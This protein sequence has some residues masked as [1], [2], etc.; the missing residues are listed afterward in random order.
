MG[1]KTPPNLNTLIRP[2]NMAYKFTDS[3]SGGVKNSLTPFKWHLDGR[4]FLGAG[5]HGNLSGI[6]ASF[7]V[8]VVEHASSSL[9][10]SLG[11]VLTG[12]NGARIDIP[13]ITHFLP[14][15]SILPSTCGFSENPI[16]N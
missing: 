4:R 11:L 8:G 2:L 1:S 10:F 6:L 9:S 7:V 3:K 15:D 5:G 14:S 16:S 12:L 13:A